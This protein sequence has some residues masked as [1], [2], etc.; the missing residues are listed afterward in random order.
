MENY[1]SFVKRDSSSLQ[2]FIYPHQSMAQFLESHNEIYTLPE[3]N[4]TPAWPLKIGHPKR[5]RSYSNHPFSGAFAVSFRDG[6]FLWVH[7]EASCFTRFHRREM[8]QPNTFRSFPS[9]L[10][11][12]NNFE[13]SGKVLWKD[14]RLKQK[15][16]DIPWNPG[17]LIGILIISGQIK[18]FH[19]PR[20][21]WNK[22]I[23]LP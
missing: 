10:P 5:K 8:E 6:T 21:P 3:T 9:K 15:P 18:I 19:K 7:H 16:C 20:S 12:V 4:M 2:Q 14:L 22:G 1:R 13:G 23:S 17:W 11:Q